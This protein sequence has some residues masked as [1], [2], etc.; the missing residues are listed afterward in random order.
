M[1]TSPVKRCVLGALNPNISS[2]MPQ[3][4]AGT[5]AALQQ[6]SVAPSPAPAVTPGKR[7]IDSVQA[8]PAC[9]GDHGAKRARLA[10]DMGGERMAHPQ[11][12]RK[13]RSPS[14]ADDSIFD[15]SAADTSHATA[16]TEPDAERYAAPTIPAL[17]DLAGS[18]P[19]RPAPRLTRQQ[20]REKA[21]ILRLRLGLA[22]YKVR[23]GQ[24]DV[25]LERL[26][27]RPIPGAGAGR[28]PIS[29]RRNPTPTLAAAAALGVREVAQ[30]RADII[31]RFREVAQMNALQP[32]Q[33]RRLLP[34]EPV[35][36][37]MDEEEDDDD[38]EPD[39]LPRLPPQERG[40]GS[41]GRRPTTPQR[42]R[43]PRDEVELSSSALRGGAARGFEAGLPG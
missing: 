41:E 6:S 4:I 10:A 21:E 42:T 15:N 13:P 30:A 1:A 11:S 22:N 19:R 16:I 8:S 12:T 24:T 38:D 2:P 34:R 17:P 9:G 43:P 37:P 26:Q 35:R 20:A 14:P 33:A 40:A 28:A 25:P 3:P 18:V 31:G 32:Q 36:R 23:T 39:A 7:T 29:P 27:Q 5:K